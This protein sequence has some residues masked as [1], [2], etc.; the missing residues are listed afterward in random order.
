MMPVCPPTTKCT[1]Q[2]TDEIDGARRPCVDLGDADPA[3]ARRRSGIIAH[4]TALTA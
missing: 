4:G 2:D 3:A 1:M